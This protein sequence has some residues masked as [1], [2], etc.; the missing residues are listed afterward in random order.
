MREG[1]VPFA[2]TMILTHYGRVDVAGRTLGPGGYLTKRRLLTD[3]YGALRRHLAGLRPCADD[4][5]RSLGRLALD[6][7]PEL[8]AEVRRKVLDGVDLEAACDALTQLPEPGDWRAV[9][10]ALGDLADAGAA[11]ASDQLASGPAVSEAAD[12]AGPVDVLVAL[13]DRAPLDWPG[14]V[15][16]AA[17]AGELCTRRPSDL[18]VWAP[19]GAWRQA[20]CLLAMCKSASPDRCLVLSD[21]RPPL[22]HVPC[23]GRVAV[24][25]EL[26][27]GPVRSGRARFMCGDLRSDRV[28]RVLLAGRARRHPELEPLLRLHV[29]ARTLH[30]GQV[31]ERWREVLRVLFASGLRGMMPSELTMDLEDLAAAARHGE[32]AVTGGFHALDPLVRGPSDWESGARI[33]VP[34]AAGRSPAALASVNRWL[35]ANAGWELAAPQRQEELR[36]TAARLLQRLADDPW[37]DD[38]QVAALFDEA[39]RP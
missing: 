17:A 35:D 14:P 27:R 31:I 26:R 38:E 21:E 15:L 10:R 12:Y 34:L 19:A 37:P 24:V 5:D 22:D 29:L 9:G 23:D 7:E 20:F 2:P 32:H 25:T 6:L 33:Y 39:A 11:L 18:T 3:P 8:T 28:F 13:E 30:G 16:D 4:V 1:L 36:A